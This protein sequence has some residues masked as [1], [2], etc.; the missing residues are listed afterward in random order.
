MPHEGVL[1]CLL[2]ECPYVFVPLIGADAPLGR[3]V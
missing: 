2:S 1:L 3:L